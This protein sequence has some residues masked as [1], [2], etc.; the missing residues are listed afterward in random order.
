[1]SRDD[2][3]RAKVTKELLLRIGRY[4]KPYWKQIALTLIAVA[5]G[6]A[7]SLVPTMMTKNIIDVALP[8]RNLAL[9]AR[10]A[11][12]S[13]GATFVL[14]LMGVGE[15]YLN[16]WVSK[17][18]ICDMR[19]SMY[20]HLQYMSMRFFSNT[21]IGEI[22]SRL[23]NDVSGIEGVFSGTIIRVVRNF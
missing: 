13:F 21:K 9:L 16:T 6:Q 10:F 15:S 22:M 17:Q 20:N 14:G 4:Y 23:N 11:L 2:L 5:V 19:N 18:I 7:L 3:P 8:Q 12:L 1:Y